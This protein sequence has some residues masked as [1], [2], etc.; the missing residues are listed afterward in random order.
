MNNND[1]DDFLNEVN[2]NNGVVVNATPTNDQVEDINYSEIIPPEQ[3]EDGYTT[4]SYTDSYT[5]IVTDEQTEAVEVFNEIEQTNSPIR[6]AYNLDENN[7]KPDQ[8]GVRQ[9]SAEWFEKVREL[10]ITIAGVGGIGSYVAFLM[11][12]IHPRN[13]HIYDDDTIDSSNLTGQMFYRNWV[14]QDKVN[15]VQMLLSKFC[16]YYPSTFKRRVD[17]N[18]VL[19]PIVI[20]GFDNMAAR[21]T[22]FNNWLAM[23]N[24][25]HCQMPENKKNYLYIDGRLAAENWQIFCIRGDDDYNIERYQREFLFDD[26]QAEEPICSYKQT[27]FCATMIA[28]Y[29][30]NL[31]INHVCNLDLP[32]RSMPFY[33]RYEASTMYL[34]TE[35]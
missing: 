13:I 33:T 9:S 16:N 31:F 20:T 6:N 26:N 30:V 14:G 15:A 7:Y 35:D 4:Y 34:K 24:N 22:T 8:V 2:S 10:S 17:N 5:E 12:R 21:K 18:T 25:T 23:V 27:S 3:Q 11:G 32:M 29:M 1:I 19:D 28:S